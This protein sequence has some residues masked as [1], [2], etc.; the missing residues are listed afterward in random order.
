MGLKALSWTRRTLLASVLTWMF[1]LAGGSLEPA[2]HEIFWAIALLAGL[3]IGIS[4][5]ACVLLQSVSWFI[6]MQHGSGRTRTVRR[7]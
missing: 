1:A 7:G 2:N 4:A 5:F 6:S 3:G